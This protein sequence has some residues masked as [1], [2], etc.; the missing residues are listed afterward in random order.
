MWAGP[1]HMHATQGGR[2]GH[3]YS[4]ILQRSERLWIHP[5]DG[6]L[7][8]HFRTCQRGRTRR[9]EYSRGR[10]KGQLRRRH[11]T[12]QAS[13]R[14]SQGAL[15]RCSAVV[16]AAVA[17]V[18]SEADSFCA[19]CVSVAT[20]ISARAA[21]WVSARTVKFKS[22]GACYCG[23]SSIT[24]GRHAQPTALHFSVP[25]RRTA[26]SWAALSAAVV[27]IWRLSRSVRAQGVTR[28]RL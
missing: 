21:R 25:Q 10:P 9:Y 2:D 16:A 8:R 17:A 19:V 7:E 3:R 26:S 28:V 15:S 23:A 22:W 27:R 24:T 5:T 4:Q 18:L 20:S 14:E 6:R 1:E 13:G 11:R 12:R